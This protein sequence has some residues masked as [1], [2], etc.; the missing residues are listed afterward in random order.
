M[1]GDTDTARTLVAEQALP[2]SAAAAAAV[3]GV[4][5]VIVDVQP[6]RSCIAVTS[7]AK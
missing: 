2:P 5:V 7:D 4:A 3:A 1:P 6:Y